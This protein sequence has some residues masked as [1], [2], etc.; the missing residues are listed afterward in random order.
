MEPIRNIIKIRVNNHEYLY[1]FKNAWD[2]EKQRSYSRHRTTVGKLVD[3]KV[4]L[5]RKFLASHPEYKDIDFKFEDNKLLAI[6]DLPEVSP[7]GVNAVLS[8]TFPLNAGAAYVLKEIARQTGLLRDLKAIFSKN[9]EDLLALAMFFVIY[10]DRNLSNFD[11][12]ASHSQLGGN[13]LDSQRISEL[14]EGITYDQRQSYMKRRMTSSCENEEN[15]FWAFDTTSISSF[16]QTL[17]KVAHGN[18]KEDPDIAM[19]KIAL[20]I[21]ENT[22]EPLYYKVLNGSIADVTLLRN[23]FVDLAQ[24]R[25]K[26]INLV[27]DRGFCSENNLLMMF[28]NHVGF[29]CGLRSDPAIAAQ[30]VSQLV[31]S[32][33][34]SLPTAYSS[35][36]GCYCATKKIDWF[37]STR[38]HGQ[39]TFPFYVHVYYD[40]QRETNEILNMTE[41]VDSFKTR[42]ENKEVPNN[43][44][45]RRFFKKKN[46]GKTEGVEPKEL[47]EF[48]VNAWVAFTKTCGC[49]VLGSNEV[50]SASEAL[51]I[52]RQKDTVEKAFNNYKDKCEGRRLR[53]REGALEGKV[54]VTYL[55]LCLR[56]ML[57]K[58]LEQA[59]KNPLDTPRVLERFNS[60]VQYRHV[61][62]DKTKLYWQEIPKE[63]RLLMEELK[64]KTPA[65]IFTI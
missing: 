46:I 41:M 29:V 5:G 14:L 7:A 34:L 50:A 33:R 36:V 1:Q 28:R 17:L 35:S 58:R 2:K 45:F 11:L 32:L 10:P 23:L 9:W 30:T 18:N 3:G 27:L 55:S 54:F 38:A 25:G 47:Y 48:D 6:S 53:C 62:D 51:N 26:Q 12:T 52:Y 43:S 19:I 31:P 20:L 16:S 13:D 37:S 59:G 65:P 21:D 40:K 8:K 56:L 63:D 22:G 49:F 39:E 60:I 4:Q 61:S 64:I 42:L 44:Y 15:N 57:E 24:L